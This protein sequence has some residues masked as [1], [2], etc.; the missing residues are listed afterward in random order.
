MKNIFL[1]L[2]FLIVLASGC[3]SRG[4]INSFAGPLPEKSAVAAIADD[5]AFIL[6]GLYP[7]GHTALRLLPAKNA[8]NSFAVVF[9]SSLRGKGFTLAATDSDTLAVAYT[10]D[11]LDEKTAWYLHL[12]LS[13]GK[14]IARCYL[15]NGQP[16]GGQSQALLEPQ[17]VLTRIREAVRFEP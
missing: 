7:P 8:E 4:P 10:L 9:E 2:C 6:A 17:S 12:R 14:V 11:V 13:D 5:A 3:V 16:E 15:A 1:S